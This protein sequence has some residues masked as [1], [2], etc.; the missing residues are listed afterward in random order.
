MLASLSCYLFIY[1]RATLGADQSIYSNFS[2]KMF[3]LV[4]LVKYVQ[5]SKNRKNWICLTWLLYILW[6]EITFESQN[7]C[8]KGN[9]SL[10]SCKFGTIDSWCNYLDSEGVPLGALCPNSGHFHVIG[11]PAFNKG[12]FEKIFIW[13]SP[14]RVCKWIWSKNYLIRWM[15]NH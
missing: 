9:L 1:Q 14:L 8:S 5:M 12:A 2:P 6:P 15:T 10:R 4:L 13:L 3:K 11:A 7:L